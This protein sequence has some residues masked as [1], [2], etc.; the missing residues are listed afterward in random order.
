MYS[1]IPA[2]PSGKLVSEWPA[3]WQSRDCHAGSPHR[4]LSLCST[5]LTLP[6]TSGREGECCSLVKSDFRTPQWPSAPGGRR[7]K[8]SPASR[9]TAQPPHPPG[10]CGPPHGGRYGCCGGH[11]LSSTR[12]APSPHLG[13]PDHSLGQPGLHRGESHPHG[14]ALILTVLGELLLP[15]RHRQRR[16]PHKMQ[17]GDK[18]EREKTHHSPS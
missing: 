18:L 9:Q 15:A 6:R 1:F 3:L 13:Y 2:L 11:N 10:L 12:S 17:T 4:C 14:H 5:H 16:S 8:S 7:T